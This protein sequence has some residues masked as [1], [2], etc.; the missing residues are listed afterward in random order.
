MV[1][2]LWNYDHSLTINY[3]TSEDVLTLLCI[4]NMLFSLW[5]CNLFL[6]LKVSFVAIG[7]CYYIVLFVNK[8][9]QIDVRMR[10]ALQDIK[11]IFSDSTVENNLF[12]HFAF[13]LAISIVWKLVHT[14][15]GVCSQSSLEDIVMRLPKSMHNIHHIS[16][17]FHENY[18]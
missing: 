13:H 9:I 17:N 5:F 6:Y 3:W 18:H 8:N 1:N 12:L 7:N 4:G 15:F 10:L 16:I 14:R 2:S 11:F